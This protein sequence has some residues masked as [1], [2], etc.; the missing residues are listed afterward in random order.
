MNSEIRDIM[1]RKIF[2]SRGQLT[3]EATIS[4]NSGLVASA[5]APSGTS[6]SEYEVAAF[7]ISIDA[8]IR[9]FL[10]SKKEIIGIDAADQQALDEKLH[11]IGG[12]GLK[13]IGGSIST[14]VSIANARLAAAVE[15]MELYDYVYSRFT[16]RFVAKKRIP[17]LLGNVIGGGVHSKNGMNIQEILVSPDS[18]SLFQNA[19]LSEEL[20]KIVGD[21]IAKKSKAGI[22]RN[23]EGAWNSPFAEAENLGIV[24]RAIGYINKRYNVK[25]A[26]GIDI[27]ASEFYTNGKYKYKWGVLDT[28][29]QL[30]LVA[31][32]KNRY[33]I[34]YIEDPFDE[35][36]FKSFARLTAA[37]K[38]SALVVGDDLYA[39]NPKRLE[40]GIEE[41]ATNAILIKVNQIG[42]LSDTIKVVEIATKKGVKSIISHRSGE[43]NDAFIAHLAVA[44]GAPFIKSGISGGERVSKINEL[45]RIEAIEAAD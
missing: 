36:D 20:H 9:N 7:P 38:G 26:V 21:M 4:S 28:D 31:K 24:K 35:N 22:G 6:K 41:R 23:I 18:G 37:L 15:G 44:F 3:V 1:L 25:V 30:E 14:A 16:R 29:G 33:G 12:E 45:L 27:A 13:A 19:V 42:T 40:K 34:Y 39:T 17:R 5:S 8:C 10:K 2:D 11:E 43:T 32:L